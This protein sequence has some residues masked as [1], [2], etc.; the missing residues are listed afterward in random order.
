MEQSKA[1]AGTGESPAE[2]SSNAPEP[3][4]AKD[5]IS[6]GAA[7]FIRGVTALQAKRADEAAD[8]LTKAIS[9][10]RARPLYHFKLGQA[11]QAAGRIDEAA[12]LRFS[13]RIV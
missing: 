5:V 6:T 9:V 1:A 10:R 2:Q 11:L 3:G 12:K 13:F 8:L 7:L 4:G